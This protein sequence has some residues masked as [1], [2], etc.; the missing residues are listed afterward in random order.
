VKFVVNIA[1]GTVPRDVARRWKHSRRP[2][3]APAPPPRRT[4][5]RRW[6]RFAGRSRRSYV[7]DL[8]AV[9]R[10]LE[11]DHAGDG[12]GLTRACKYCCPTLAVVA[13]TEAT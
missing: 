1:K 4:I 5:H 9:M 3:S 6:C 2:G 12:D 11:R 13:A 10:L 8:R 7:L